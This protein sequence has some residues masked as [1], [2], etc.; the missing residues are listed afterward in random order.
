MIGNFTLKSDH[1]GPELCLRK[2]NLVAGCSLDF[3]ERQRRLLGERLA[4]SSRLQGWVTEGKG[5]ME[6]QTEEWFG[7]E[8]ELRVTSGRTVQIS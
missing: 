4:I 6:S 2:N 5:V 7:R 1:R 3:R 8:R